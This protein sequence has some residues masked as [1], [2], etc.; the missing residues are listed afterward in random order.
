LVEP[1]ASQASEGWKMHQNGNEIKIEFFGNQALFQWS[2]TKF[3][4]VAHEVFSYFTVT[5]LKLF[6]FFCYFL[7]P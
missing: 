2:S 4:E 5:V 6:D 7:S 3:K 1:R